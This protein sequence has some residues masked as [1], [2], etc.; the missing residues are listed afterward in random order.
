V[1]PAVSKGVPV[2]DGAG[3]CEGGFSPGVAVAEG[4]G[5]SVRVA[6]G[7]GLIVHVAVWEGGIVGGSA[8]TGMPCCTPAR[9]AKAVCSL[10]RSSESAPQQATIVQATTRLANISNIFLL[11]PSKTL[12]PLM[13]LCRGVQPIPYPAN[14]TSVGAF[15]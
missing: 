13:I 3:V 5:V 12:L 7:E 10:T 2:G 11:N 14:A 9:R 1:G 8:D 4:A 6:E 15:N